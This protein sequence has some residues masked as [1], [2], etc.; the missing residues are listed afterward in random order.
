MNRQNQSRQESVGFIVTIIGAIG[1]MIV[2]CSTNPARSPLEELPFEG[3]VVQITDECVV[4][5][6]C[7]IY[8]EE[9]TT[10]DCPGAGEE[11][12]SGESEECGKVDRFCLGDCDGMD[13]GGPP[14]ESERLGCE[15]VDDEG[16]NVCAGKAFGI[17]ECNT[18]CLHAPN[19][20]LSD[21]CCGTQ[22]KPEYEYF[23]EPF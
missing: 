15:C 7:V 13:C 4:D 2:A 10:P 12:Q 11:N 21:N 8:Y 17:K 3:R 16:A 19:F 18:D 23:C 22:F 14:M 20:P 5:T 9:C 1:F 6:D